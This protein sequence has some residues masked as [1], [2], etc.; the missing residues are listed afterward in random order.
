MDAYLKACDSKYDFIFLDPPYA[1]NLINP[2]LEL[3]FSRKL[4]NPEGLVIVE[5]DPKEPI[6][7]EFR[8]YLIQHKE[9]KSSA[10]SWLQ[11]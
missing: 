6:G 7:D 11:R 4:L 2:T 5:H 1:K 8:Q 10:F 9:N 3:I